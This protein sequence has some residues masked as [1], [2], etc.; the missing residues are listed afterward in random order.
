MASTPASSSRILKLHLSAVACAHH[1]GR[2]SSASASREAHHRR[3][4]GPHGAPFSAAE[5]VAL[6]RLPMPVIADA[7]ERASV[8][9]VLRVAVVTAAAADVRRAGITSDE[10]GDAV[11]LPTVTVRSDTRERLYRLPIELNGWALNCVA[12]AIDDQLRFPCEVE[13]GV[14]NGRPFAEFVIDDSST[15]QPS[16]RTTRRRSSGG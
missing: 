9:L 6:L 14:I 10:R 1:A 15:T 5:W 13:F 8:Y 2:S 11:P 7:R 4:T 16:S 12:L 3:V